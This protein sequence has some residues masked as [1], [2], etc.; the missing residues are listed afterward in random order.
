MKS[1][2]FKYFNSFVVKLYLQ[3]KNKQGVIKVRC[4]PTR[5]GIIIDLKKNPSR[6][7]VS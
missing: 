2:I 3:R 7:I 4:E 1:H 5:P 6:F